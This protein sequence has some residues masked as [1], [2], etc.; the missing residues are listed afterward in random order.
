MIE[1][2]AAERI[3][4]VLD[5][6]LVLGSVDEAAEILALAASFPELAPAL[7]AAADVSWV[8]TFVVVEPPADDDGG[9]RTM[10]ECRGVLCAA[11]G[12]ADPAPPDAGGEPSRDRQPTAWYQGLAAGRAKVTDATT[13]NK[14]LLACARHGH[15]AVLDALWEAAL[16][17]GL[18]APSSE[19]T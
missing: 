16:Q 2:D 11:D 18:P 10:G 6:R 12:S 8:T 14:V 17:H 15:Q 7:G 3:A 19:R 1:Q 5:G 4:Q 13:A 9:L